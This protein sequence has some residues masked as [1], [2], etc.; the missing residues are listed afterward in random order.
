MLIGMFAH[1]LL[2]V[3]ELVKNSLSAV[4][5]RYMDSDKV[6][7]HVR[8]CHY[9]GVGVQA[10]VDFGLEGQDDFALFGYVMVYLFT[11]GYM[12]VKKLTC[13]YRRF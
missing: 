11:F 7:P 9:K 4:Q 5:E 10:L 8:R 1:L 12:L 13:L 3:F 2:M 6:A